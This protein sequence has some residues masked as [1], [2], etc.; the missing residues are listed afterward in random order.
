MTTD[1]TQQQRDAETAAIT[2][3]I[4]SRV[5]EQIRADIRGASHDPDARNS[6]PH[7]DCPD[8]NCEFDET[9]TGWDLGFD[10]RLHVS[11]DH[12]MRIKFGVASHGTFEQ[13]TVTPE[14][15]RKFAE[16]LLV[17]SYGAPMPED[18]TS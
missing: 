11:R 16:L 7:D 12:D 18:A 13:R 8:R 17:L 3:D 14:Q 9:S 5:R 4:Q 6:F 1:T 2:A 15:L 10:T